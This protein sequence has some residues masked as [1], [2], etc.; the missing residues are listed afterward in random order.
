MDINNVTLDIK[1][2]NID[3]NIETEY[4]PKK[5]DTWDLVALKFFKDEKYLDTLIY[6]NK[7]LDIDLILS[8]DFAIN[9]PEIKKE[10]SKTLPPWRR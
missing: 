1:L 4:L 6:A 9:I 8:C 7:K 3:F 5:Y 10:I 2:I